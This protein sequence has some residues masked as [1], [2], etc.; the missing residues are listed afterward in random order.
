MP[1]FHGVNQRAEPSPL[2]TQYFTKGIC[3]YAGSVSIR[4]PKY[5][6]KSLVD[7]SV[8][9]WQE[10]SGYRW[11]EL[12]AMAV[13]TPE[14]GYA[15]ISKYERLQPVV[16]ERSWELACIATDRKFFPYMCN[17]RVISLDVAIVEA[18]KQS[19]NGYPISISK[20]VKDDYFYVK[21][22]DVNG[23]V[24][25][26]LNPDFIR[27]QQ[28]HWNLIGTEEGCRTFWTVS[29]KYEMRKK[30]KLAEGKIRTF[31]ASSVTHNLSM[32][33]LCH[34]MNNKFYRSHGK[35]PSA[36]GMSKYYGAWHALIMRLLSKG[37]KR[38]WALDETDYDAS[39]FRR[40]LWEQMKFRYKCLEEIHQTEE[41]WNRLVHLYFDIIYSIMVTPQGDVIVKD[42][43]N[44]SGQN[45]TIVDNTIGLYRKFMYA[46]FEIH[47]MN[48]AGDENRY[49][50]LWD[51]LERFD[52]IDSPQH[53][54]EIDRIEKE[55]EAIE[56][57][58][59]TP[60]NFDRH[61]NLAMCGDDNS[62]G[63]AESWIG[64]FTGRAVADVWTSI[65]VTTKSDTWDP[66]AITDLDFLSHNTEWFPEYQRY[67]PVPEFEKTMDSLKFASDLKDVRWSL[68]RA[69]ALRMES[70]PNRKAR[71]YIWDYISWVWKNHEKQ[72]TGSVVL[73]NGAVIPYTDILN[74]FMSDEELAALYCGFESKLDQGVYEYLSETFPEL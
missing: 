66:R 8:T 29:Q 34:E 16:N 24:T 74:V 50:E 58:R 9:L 4:P 56:D 65:G 45:C 3:V 63:V 19:S 36:V 69:F 11:D 35:T 18:N 27:T 28:K 5:K 59:A 38:G 33:Q 52:A 46:F 62:Y 30:K 22:F 10:A 57:R 73:K 42:T 1:H 2:F 64:W 55:M 68:L 6:D 41:N 61:V 43:G 53:S 13:P 39:F 37:I 72:L 70:W 40:E 44:P 23:S 20:T 49:M 31:T 7:P 21:I 12:H 51:Q 47:N 25:K 67:L 60:A 32:S 15:S 26:S 54:E 71:A 17:S 48:F 14:T